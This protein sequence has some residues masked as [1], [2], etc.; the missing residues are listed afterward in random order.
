MA[1]LSS[2]CEIS[3]QEGGEEHLEFQ[4]PDVI[5]RKIINHVKSESKVRSWRPAARPR[6]L[7]GKQ[8]EVSVG[9]PVAIAPSLLPGALPSLRWDVSTKTFAGTRERA[10]TQAEP[11]G[12]KTVQ[13]KP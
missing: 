6:Q 2:N 9:P 11:D 8:K 10:R 3:V 13:D 1:L 7:C 5:I 12:E 4:S